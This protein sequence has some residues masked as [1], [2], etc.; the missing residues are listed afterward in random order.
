MTTFS[1]TDLATRI[2]RDLGLV[3]AEET[4]SDAD[5]AHT[6]ETIQS[7]FASMGV[8]G[9]PVLNGS[10]ES[11]PLEYLTALSRRIGLAVAPAF[12]LITIADA[13]NA[14][15]A[16]EDVL[17]DISAARPEPLTLITPEIGAQGRRAGTF[18]WES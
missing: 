6:L 18:S 9:V 16:A 2:L 5:I 8:R 15:P 14:I 17:T 13:T 3:E 7:E 4:P 1:Q 11:I 10:D 12:G